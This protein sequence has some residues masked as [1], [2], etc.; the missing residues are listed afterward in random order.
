[1]FAWSERNWW[2]R[3]AS[4]FLVQRR[5]RRRR[6]LPGGGLYWRSARTRSSLH[7]AEALNRTSV[8]VRVMYEREASLRRFSGVSLSL[9]WAVRSAAA[10][11]HLSATSF[12]SIPLCAGTQ[13][14]V[15]L[16]AYDP[17]AHLHGDD[18][19]GLAGADD[20]RPHALSTPLT[21]PPTNYVRAKNLNPIL[22]T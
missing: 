15:T 8:A 16:P 11:A 1:M 6:P 14:M 2:G 20:V 21:A 3:P 12:P 13:R 10:L 7:S 19:E 9:H 17:V 4:S 5:R 18:S 22:G